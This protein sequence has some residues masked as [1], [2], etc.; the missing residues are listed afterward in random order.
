[1]KKLNAIEE[2]CRAG[3]TIEHII[4]LPSGNHTGKRSKKSEKTPEEVQKYNDLVAERNLRR[5]VNHNFSEGDCHFTFTYAEVPDPERAQKDLENFFRRL[6]R[7]MQKQEKE[8]KYV[9][10]TEFENKRIHHHIIMNLADIKL[11]SKTWT[12]G[13]VRASILDDSGDYTLLAN[14]LIKETQKTFRKEENV[15]K[16][17]YSA[18]RNL[19][20]PTVIRK[21]ISAKK[22]YEDP[23]PTDGYQVIKDSIQ[24]YENPITGCDTLEYREILLRRKE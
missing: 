5:L 8:L 3:K 6:R 23:T 14:Y 15:K 19:E 13:H 9:A 10:V 21:R 12:K 20:R 2:I 16:R 24:I 4:K 7:K 1:M 17:R 18:S 22:L 11:V